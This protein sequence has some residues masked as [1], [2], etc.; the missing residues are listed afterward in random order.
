RY[1]P[2]LKMNCLVYL[3]VFL[4]LVSVYALYVMA[5]DFNPYCFLCQQSNFQDMNSCMWCLSFDRD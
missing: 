2:T 1:Q 5:E 4:L 3:T